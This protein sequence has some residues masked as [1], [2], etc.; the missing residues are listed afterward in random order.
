MKFSKNL[1]TMLKFSVD[2]D[3]NSVGTPIVRVRIGDNRRWICLNAE[4]IDDAYYQ[5]EVMPTSQIIQMLR[6]DSLQMYI[7]VIHMDHYFCRVQ[8]QVDDSDIKPEVTF[9]DEPPS[10]HYDDPEEF[11]SETAQTKVNI[12]SL[13]KSIVGEEVKEI[14]IE[15][16]PVGS[17]KPI[18]EAFLVVPKPKNY[19]LTKGNLL[20][21]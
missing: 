16:P 6:C 19:T 9:N 18:S 14:K 20:D 11:G 2:I 7:D 15:Q 3:G 5:C 17:T 4:K 13:I 1:S 8:L 10:T 12:S 21:L